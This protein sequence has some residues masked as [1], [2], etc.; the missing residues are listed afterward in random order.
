MIFGDDADNRL[1]RD[2]IRKFV[3]K[4]MPPEAVRQWAR[5]AA[6]PEP[7]YR[8]WAEQGWLGI[9]LPEELGG[10]AGTPTEIITL[11]EEL[12]RHGFD[13]TGAYSVSV[14]LSISIAQHG[15]DA[16]KA[17]LLPPFL[18]GER[19]F[20]TALTEPDTGSDLSGIKC[21]ARP[22]EDGW[23]I[24]GEK[25]FCSGAHLPNTTILVTCRTGTF[26]NPRNGLTILLVPN[27]APGL[28]IRRMDTLGRKT[29]GTNQLHFD[30]VRVPAT[31]V[32]GR[33]DHAWSA[34]S[35]TLDLERLFIAAGYVGNAQAALDLAATYAQ[36][37]IQFGRPIAKFQAVAHK[38]VDMRMRVDAARLLTYR[39]AHLMGQGQPCR[40]EASIAKL[41][42]SEALVR[43]TND[44]MQVLGGYGYTTEMDMERW[45]RD[46]RVTTV[47]GGTSEIQRNIVAHEMGL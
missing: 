23:Q 45:F 19:H 21:R 42:A 8:K 20:C 37:R 31:A 15:T 44:G 17:G 11:G 2:S 28:T 9:G 35:T 26:D 7:L 33:V 34:L 18:K 41:A 6:F 27:D 5:E 32:L 25:L 3:D 47:M 12:A 4:E 40:A 22:V 39:A 38:L 43:V 10:S 30:G 29:F 14:F 13:I 36:Q 1:F 46:A 24:D 16:Q